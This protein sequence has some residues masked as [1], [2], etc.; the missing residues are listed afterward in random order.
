MAKGVR[1]LGVARP[2][3]PRLQLLL[4]LVLID[5]SFCAYTKDTVLLS[6]A[7]GSLK[8]DRGG[9]GCRLMSEMV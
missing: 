7:L 9:E 2:D 8:V 6:K 4:F 1:H 5:F 3:E